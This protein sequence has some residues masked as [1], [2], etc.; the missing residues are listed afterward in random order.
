MHACIHAYIHVYTSSFTF[1]SALSRKSKAHHQGLRF[2]ASFNAK[3]S[4]GLLSP[5]TDSSPHKNDGWKTNLSFSNRLFS[6]DICS[7]FGGWDTSTSLAI[8]GQHLLLVR[9]S[10][11]HLEMIVQSPP[12][13]KQHF[14]HFHNGLFGGLVASLIVIGKTGIHIW[15]E[16]LLTWTCHGFVC[17]FSRF[18]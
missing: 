3:W 11:Y 17:C 8:S 7:F 16:S 13:A 14:L 4:Q 10:W 1:P 2:A 5:K 6:W 15:N 9:Q 12:N 18:L